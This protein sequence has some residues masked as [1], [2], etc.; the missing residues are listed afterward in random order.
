[1]DLNDHNKKTGK[2]GLILRIIN[3]IVV[4]GGG[5]FLLFF[6][7]QE[8]TIEDIKNAILGVYRPS[9]II[10]LVLIFSIDFFRSYR[11][12]ILIGPGRISMV[13]LF[14]VSLVRNGF[15]M[16]LPARTGE[17]SYIYVLKRKFSLPIEIGVSTLMIAVVF[18][19]V[20]VFS[21]ILI[22]IIIVGINRYAVSS[23]SVILIAGGL[24]VFFLLFL[25]YLSGFIGLFI[26]LYDKTMINSRIGKTKVMQYLYDKLVET[27]KNIEIIRKRG[28]Y[29]KVY[30]ITIPA[31]LLKFTAYYF[32]IHAVLQPMGYGF[33][34]LPYWV[35]FLATAAAEMSAVLPTHSLAGLG[36]YQGAFALAFVLLGFSERIS[37]TVGFSYHIINLVFTVAWSLI[38]L[39]ILSMPFYRFKKHDAGNSL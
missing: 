12:K 17:L 16:V 1:M 28:V 8:V 32:L 24:L 30:L 27:K 11:A 7:L 35:I 19:L 2:K 26:K 18:D 3:I 29:W 37:I 36:T 23:T 31:R 9:L 22:S 13:D 4:V 21:M 33:G 39:L 20:M 34:D 25:F 14:L 15:N 10:G 5:I 6:L 38:A